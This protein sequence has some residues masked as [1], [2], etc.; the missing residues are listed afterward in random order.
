MHLD[1]FTL[2]FRDELIRVS[3][4]RNGNFQIEFL[5][6][7]IRVIEHDHDE[8]QRDVWVFADGEDPELAAEIGDLIDEHYA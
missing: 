3:V 1:E 2:S 4:L 8:S 6:K 7:T 5:D